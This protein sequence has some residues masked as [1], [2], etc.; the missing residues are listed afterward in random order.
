MENLTDYNIDGREDDDLL[1]V[2]VFKLRKSIYATESFKL[3]FVLDD[4]VVGSIDTFRTQLN[5]TGGPSVPFFLES[6]DT[7]A[8]NVEIMV[9]PY[10]SN[11]FRESSLD[12]SGNPQK[13]I[14]VFTDNFYN[15]VSKLSA[16]G[17]LSATNKFGAFQQQ[18][19]EITNK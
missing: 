15:E 2:G 11:K 13:K 7:N 8:R 19:D 17:S 10:I 5:P 16:V 14:R 9:N 4:R 3:D 12:V 18:L 1:N 6:Q